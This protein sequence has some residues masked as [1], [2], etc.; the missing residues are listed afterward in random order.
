M[1][2]TYATI[3]KSCFNNYRELIA[4]KKLSGDFVKIFL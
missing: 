1:N 2:L 4:I 3:L